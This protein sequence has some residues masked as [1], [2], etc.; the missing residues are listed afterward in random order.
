MASL[1]GY[2]STRNTV[3]PQT[4]AIPGKEH[5]MATNNAGGVSFKLDDW[6]RLE[7]FLILGTEGGTYYVTERKL[8]RDN[9]KTIEGLLKADGLR[10][11]EKVVEISKEGRAHKNDAALFVLAMA[12]AAEDPKVRQAALAALPEVARTGTHLFTFVE[13]V[14]G[15]R[16]WGRGLKRAVTSWY[17]NMD[18]NRLAYQL[19]KYQ[20]RNGWSHRDLLRLSHPK[21]DNAE[22]NTLFKWCVDGMDGVKA[23]GC[24]HLLHRQVVAM[25]DLHRTGDLKTAI[26]LIKDHALPREAVPTQFLNKPEVWDA[27]LPSMGLTAMIRNLGN[28]GK[29]GLLVDG[30]QAGQFIRN[31]LLDAELLAKSRVHPLQILAALLTYNS[32]R[33]YR[34]SGQWSVVQPVVDALDQAFYASFKNVPVTGKAFLLGVDVSGSMSSPVSGLP[35]L[36]CRTAAAAMALVTANVESNYAIYG[37]TAGSG[38]WGSRDT[39]FTDLKISP[40]MRLDQV[41]A[42]MSNQEFGGTDCSLPMVWALKNKLKF[43]VF[44]VYTDNETWAGNIQPAEALRQYRDAFGPAKQ[45][46][47]GMTASNFT[48]ADPT[49]TN[50]LDVV[51][52]DASTPQA[53]AHFV[54][55]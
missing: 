4:E 20:Q 46:V 45:V 3:T 23:Q 42:V 17:L 25:H 31:Q 33:G 5:L 18:A 39:G 44:G 27:M 26:A 50:A 53:I 22:I 41:E 7:R 15:F 9:A 29:V 8:T 30:S 24:E 36:S 52:F 51:G 28:M 48:I 43:D 13:Y 10:V 21:I 1:R 49:D 47:V 16:G 54:S 32:G 14:E 2:Y 6:K 40:R 55:E 38:G 35:F 34:G 11:I 37:F 12:A 19:I